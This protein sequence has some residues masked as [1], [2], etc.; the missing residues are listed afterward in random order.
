LPVRATRVKVRAPVALAA[1]IARLEDEAA[2]ADS[3]CQARLAALVAT[4]ALAMPA[5]N[6]PELRAQLFGRTKA[7][8]VVFVALPEAATADAIASRLR[9]ELEASPGYQTF[10]SVVGKVRSNPE[11][12][13]AVFLREGYLY[14]ESPELAALFGSLTLSLLFRDPE[15]RIARGS[16]ELAARRLNDGDYEYTSGSEQGRRAKL[17]LFDRVT[18]AGAMLA[19]PRHVDLRALAQQLGFDELSLARLTS[20]GVAA[21]AVYGAARVPTLLRVERGAAVRR[22]QDRGRPAR[23]SPAPRVA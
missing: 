5:V 18:A 20:E 8:P 16:E 3:Q 11:L 23:R 15:L 4:P 2:A 9:Q 22:A 14:T 10:G 13:R 19:E 21:D 17:L 7:A 6:Q 1:A 12:A